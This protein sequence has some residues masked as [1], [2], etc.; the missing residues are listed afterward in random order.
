MPSRR[1]F[2]L[3]T[4]AAAASSSDSLLAQETDKALTPLR[5]LILGGTGTTGRYYVQA[6]LDRGH[7]V[8]V[9]SRGRAHANLPSSVESLIGD[10]NSDLDSIENR[11]WDAVIDV[12]TYGPGWVRSL[13]QALKGR[14]RH[15][16]FI[17]TIS[18]YDNPA[19]NAETS[20]ES[21]VLSYHGA[22]DPY[23]ITQEGDDYGAAK[24]L[25]ERESEKQFPGRTL[26]L[27]PGYIGGPDDTHGILTY[28]AERAE[29][30]GA[31]LAG[32]DPATPVQ[33]IDVRD[34]GAWM[35]RLAE[36][37]TTGTYNAIGPKID[38]Q[39]M[40]NS[41]R[42]NA[43]RISR[44]TWTP[45]E[46]LGARGDKAL[47]GTL[48]FWEINKGSLTRISNRKALADGLLIRPLGVTLADTL[49]WYKQQPGKDELVTGF[50]K[51][52]DGPGFVEVHTPWSEYLDHERDA[53]QAWNA[54]IPKRN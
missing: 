48:L 3:S 41:A 51:R 13:G 12:A 47:W 37:Q 6:A 14:A 11:D 26:V 22:S 35:I 16:T 28:W 4:F 1:N 20:E 39:K 49:T 44:V 45:M 25:C 27:R 50:R 34:L 10:R 33:Y 15:Y 46:W 38:Q 40:V 17:S 9:F 5:I 36:K 30:G 19:K 24:I 18:V 43:Q 21:P 31:I 42:D 52:N 54:A 23:L 29:R 2:L 32:G 53:I 8:A 7:R